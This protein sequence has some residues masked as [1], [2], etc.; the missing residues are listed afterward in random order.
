M[1]CQACGAAVSRDLTYCNRC[2]ARLKGEGEGERNGSFDSTVWA[3]VVLAVS[4]LGIILGGLI[5]LK[6]MGLDEWIIRTFM[7]LGFLTIFF[8]G[9]ALMRQLFL[10]NARRRRAENFTAA[11]AKE[12]GTSEL[13]HARALHEPPASVVEGTTRKF[14]PERVER[15]RR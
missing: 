8:T 9:G 1:F 11:A 10:L 12:L 15:Q 4:A 2:G 14:E 6:A 7:L 5:A 13:E 3:I